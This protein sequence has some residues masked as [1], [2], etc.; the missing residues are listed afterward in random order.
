[1]YSYYDNTHWRA[2]IKLPWRVMKLG[3]YP[4][5]RLWRRAAARK[6]LTSSVAYSRFMQSVHRPHLPGRTNYVPLGIS[7]KGSPAKVQSR[8]RIPIRFGFVA[9]FQQH[10]GIGD[11][12][13]AA[14]SLKRE[15]FKFELHI[16]GPNQESGPAEVASRGLEDRVFLRGVYQPED[17]WEIYSQMDVALMATTVCEPFGRVPLEAASAG[18]PTIAPAIGGIPESI[19][20]D[21]DGLLFKFRDSGDLARQMRRILEEPELIGRLIRNLKPVVDTRNA[22]EAIEQ[23]YLETLGFAEGRARRELAV[24]G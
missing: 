6:S 16:W 17:I 1:M 22:G 18:A 3:I 11:A 4:A 20:D 21:V 9:G 24:A 7:L 23:V 12:L 5:Y 8:P 19:R 2:A 13:D 15:A 14:A 10:K